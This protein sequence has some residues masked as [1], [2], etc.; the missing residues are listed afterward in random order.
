MINTI[1]KLHRIQ[2]TL[3]DRGTK[4]NKTFTLYFDNEL[5]F[6]ELV[7]KIKTKLLN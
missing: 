3:L 2:F 1:K 6:K 7:D 5:E 4:E